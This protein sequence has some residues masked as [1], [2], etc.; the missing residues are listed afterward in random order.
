MGFVNKLKK[1]YDAFQ[2]DEV[3]DNEVA[4]EK[5]VFEEQPEPII[6]EK[7]DQVSDDENKVEESIKKGDSFEQFV[8]DKFS[9]KYFSIVDWTTD[10]TRKYNRKVESNSNPDLCFRYTPNDDRFAVECKFRSGL[11]QGGISWCKKYQMDKYKE[12]SENND[13]PLYIVIG[14]GGS[15]ESPERMFCI[16]I[17]EAKYTK[18]YPSI[19]ENYERNTDELFFWDAENKNLK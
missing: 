12:Y 2:E 9:K 5:P 16:P 14:L 13:I 11:Y 4:S 15:P 18:L 7:E 10:V 6:E 19:F 1:A 17:E 8:A 3:N